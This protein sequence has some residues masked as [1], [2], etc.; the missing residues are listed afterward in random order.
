MRDA[1]G[2]K[3]RWLLF[4]GDVDHVL[5]WLPFGA[6]KRRP[7][8]VACG[9]L[10]SL[11]YLHCIVIVKRRCCLQP[12]PKRAAICNPRENTLQL[13]IYCQGWEGRGGG[14][15]GGG[16]SSGSFA[17][18]LKLKHFLV[19]PPS[20][21]SRRASPVGKRRPPVALPPPEA[22]NLTAHINLVAP[23][24]KINE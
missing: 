21:R 19:F 11:C 10:N 16:G 3:T 6:L 23:N 13:G 12:K 1:V 20:R 2:F 24:E 18:P 14:G 4:E 17:R 9:H 22:K 5:V 8:G 7:R 15:G